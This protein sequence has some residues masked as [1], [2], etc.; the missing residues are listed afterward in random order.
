MPNM[1]ENLP[2]IV[3]VVILLAAAITLLVLLTSGGGNP[4]PEG[5]VT[6]VSSTPDFS[7]A[8]TQTFQ[9]L[10]TSTE[11]APTETQPIE[12]VAETSTVTATS[13]STS[14]PT[15]NLCDRAGFVEDVTI[16]DGTEIVAG[17]KFTKTW[18]LSNDGTCTWTSD[19]EVVFAS[20]DQMDGPDSKQLTSGSVAPGE[21]VKIS[22]DLK[23]PSETGTYRG[24]WLLSNARG[25]TFGIFPG[26]SPFWVDIEV[27]EKP[28]ATSGPTGTATPT[29]TGAP[30][31]TSTATPTATE[32][33][34]TPTATATQE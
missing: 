27:I 29:A 28:K 7:A 15:A 8:Q 3:L 9:A 34:P 1:R 10:P 14:A 6:A 31:A 22:V 2:L 30:A 13:I 32:A 17:G 21:T 16:P 19:Y 33:N 25:Q 18:K 20:G 24:Y 26:N 4:A 5:T 12:T 11:V 23:A